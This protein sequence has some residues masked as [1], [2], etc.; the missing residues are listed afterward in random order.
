[1]NNTQEKKE[2]IIVLDFGGQFNQLIVRRIRDLGVYSELLPYSTSIERIKEISP[3]AIVFTGGPNSVF[4]KESLTVSAE[5]LNLGIPILGICY[6]AQLIAHMT[7]GSVKTA[8]T[9]EYGKQEIS[10]SPSLIF[11]EIPQ[12]NICWMS[13]TDFV[14]SIPE[15]YKI[16]GST[17]TCKIAAFGDEQNKIY[18]LQ[19]HPEVVHT[20]FGT[21]IL[22]NFV[23]KVSSATGNWTMKNFIDESVKKIQSV[24]GD[25]YAICAMS[26]GVDSAVAATLV[27]RAIGD[28]LYCLLVDP[29]IMRKNECSEILS[30]FRDG[31]GMN[32][33]LINASDRFLKKLEGV[34]DPEKKRKIIGNEFIRVFEDERSN[35]VG[36]CDFLVQGTIYPDVVESG[37]NESSRIKSHHNVGGLPKVIKFASIIEPLRDL[38]KDEV[39]RVGFELGLPKAVVMRQPFPGP[40]LAI[41]IIGSVT[42]EK[43]SILRDA[44]AI[45]REEIAVAGLDTEIWQY[46]AV[47]TNTKSVGVMG[48]SRTY[49]NTLAIRAV[50]SVDAMSAD[51]ARIPWP[52]LEKISTR[53]INECRQI[54]RV[55]Y[56]ITSKPPASIE[57]E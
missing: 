28:K 9:R 50:T 16:L 45:L 7:G 39:R 49:D 3:I 54:N 53:I 33:R 37:F 32:L 42:E 30:V 25:K 47:L 12:K 55:V 4:G 52:V 5:L 46:F 44:D 15:N 29:G 22:K 31:L 35:I 51:W 11:D 18:G 6:G 14:D 21:E 8:Q 26:G 2:I 34:A 24:V 56:D 1:M 19:F 27:H 23:Y 13:H 38:F 20:A 57:W 17:S 41:R 40:G 10:Y 36:R 43:L 48:D